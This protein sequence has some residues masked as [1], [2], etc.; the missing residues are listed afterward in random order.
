MTSEER[1]DDLKV[2][3]FISEDGSISSNEG[4]V[5][6][7]DKLSNSSGKSGEEGS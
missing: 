4:E 7:D 5:S 1:A 6:A 2:E 3:E